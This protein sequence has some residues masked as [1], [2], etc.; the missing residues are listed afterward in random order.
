MPGTPLLL[1]GGTDLELMVQVAKRDLD[2]GVREGVPVLVRLDGEVH[3]LE[4]SAVAPIATGPGRTSEV[5]ISVPSDLA[6]APTHGT[7]ARVDFL[8]AEAEDTVAVSQKALTTANGADAVFL[9]DSGRARAVTVT[10][11]IRD[12]GMVAVEGAITAGTWVAVSNLDLLRDGASVF[13]VRPAGGDEVR[14]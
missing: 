9:I 5:K 3:R 13:A 4:I 6:A 7:S 14:Q 8:I 11:G 1:L 12:R 10:P 2:R